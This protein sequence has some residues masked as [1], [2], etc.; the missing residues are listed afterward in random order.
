MASYNQTKRKL[1]P[2][3]TDVFYCTVFNAWRANTMRANFIVENTTDQSLS[4]RVQGRA[5][6]GSIWFNLGTAAFT[7]AA[8]NVTPAAGNAEIDENWGEMRV[9]ITPAGAPTVGEVGVYVESG[10]AGALI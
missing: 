7:V 5:K 10:F 6:E 2:R 9:Q 1:Q 3:T 8:G 4:C